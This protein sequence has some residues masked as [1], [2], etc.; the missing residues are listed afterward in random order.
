MGI[1]TAYGALAGNQFQ[2]T[3][4]QPPTLTGSGVDGDPF[5]VTS[6]YDAMSGGLPVIHVT[7]R[8]F[9][10]NGSPDVTVS[11]TVT[12]VRQDQMTVSAVR[13]FEAGD[14]VVPATTAAPARSPRST[15]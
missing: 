6:N 5:V 10:V 11:Y 2:A 13:L 1:F 8:V 4:T 15:A 14:L 12:N 7:G 9:Y 3:A